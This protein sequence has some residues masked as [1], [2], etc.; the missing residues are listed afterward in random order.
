MT[1]ILFVC[2]GNIIRSQIAEAVFKDMVLKEDLEDKI[3]VD[4]AGTSGMHDGDYPD[5]RTI[6]LLETHGLNNYSKS[7][8][9]TTSDIETFDYILAMD[10]M[11]LN[12]IN[13]F[14]TPNLTSESTIRLLR[15]YSKGSDEEE[16]T[17]PYYGTNEDFENTYKIIEESLRGLLNYLKKHYNLGI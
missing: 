5:P 14:I 9:I 16:I 17:D 10:R 6:K 2:L 8:K 7:R 15:Q 3:Y 12:D 4:S 13:S 11:N 1:K